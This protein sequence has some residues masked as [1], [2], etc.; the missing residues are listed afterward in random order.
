MFTAKISDESQVEAFEAG[1]DA[2][3]T[4]PISIALLKKRIDNLIKKSES[5]TLVGE[6]SN[7]KK[8]YSK[9][10]QNFILR[11]REVVEDN[12]TNDSFNV[13]LL[14]TSLGM[15]HST[16]YRRI[17]DVTEMSVVEF[18]NDYRIFRAVRFFR[19]G[20]RNVTVV[21]V[22]CG[23]NDLKNFRELFKRKTGMTPRQFIGQL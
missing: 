16:L 18:I 11:C 1:A 3:L 17:K 10:D 5:V 4:K 12:L 15:S 9:E 2:Y 13:D 22:K 21:S 20:E 23:F 8:K 7:I 19:E 14:A 6:I